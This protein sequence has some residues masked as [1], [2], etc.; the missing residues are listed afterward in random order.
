MDSFYYTDFA[1][2]TR[3][4]VT[5]EDLRALAASGVVNST[6][7]VAAVGSQQWSPINALVPEVPPAPGS[8]TE[9][10]AIW[11][12]CLSLGGVLCCG[13]ISSVPGII[14]GHI[15]LSRIARQPNLQGR[16]FALAGTIIGYVI[17]VFWLLYLL[18]F[19]GLAVFGAFAEKLK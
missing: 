9:P 19:G 14:C 7:M 8:V 3:G 1:G 11:S 16:A 17:T 4:P 2:E 13:I 12:L 15:S 10:L 18:L 5:L 6:S